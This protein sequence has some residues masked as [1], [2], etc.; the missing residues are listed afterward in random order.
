MRKLKTRLKSPLFWVF[1]LFLFGLILGVPFLMH[2][3]LFY[4]W[5]LTLSFI[6]VLFAL[7]VAFITGI[8]V[9]GYLKKAKLF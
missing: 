1:E 3:K 7:F 8:F 5:L 6:Q 9:E 4:E 2:G